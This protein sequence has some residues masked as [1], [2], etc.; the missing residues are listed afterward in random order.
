MQVIGGPPTTGS[1][2]VAK[3]DLNAMAPAAALL[4]TALNFRTV[5]MGTNSLLPLTLTNRGNA[6]LAITSIGISGTSVSQT[7][8]C[9]PALAPTTSCI[10]NVTFSPVST[11]TSTGRITVTDSAFDSPHFATLTG[12]GGTVGA[13]LS[14]SSLTFGNQAVGTTSASQHI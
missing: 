9:A 14:V 8:D 12:T 1:S 6:D 2:F 13:S 5:A 10:I 11:A 7:N 3:I 4:P